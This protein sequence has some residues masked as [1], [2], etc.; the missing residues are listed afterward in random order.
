[1]PQLLSGRLPNVKIG[2]PSYS[3]D[4]ATLSVVGI[5]SLDKIS[6]GG[7]IGADG[8]YLVSTGIGLTWKTLSNEDLSVVR[9]SYDFAATAGQTTFNLEYKVGYADVFV[10][11]VLLASSE[12]TATDGSSIVLSEALFAGDTVQVV[13]YN[14][15][16][17][18]SSGGAISAG[19]TTGNY[20]QYLMSTGTGLEWEDFPTLRSENN[21]TATAGQTTFN[22]TY[23][24]GF[25]DV[26]VNGVRLTSVDYT[27]SNGTS[28]VL[29][30]ALFADDSVDILAYNTTSTG[31][32]GGGGGSE[33]DTLDS[34]TS[35]GSS[36]TNSITVGA[37][38][39]ASFIKDPNSNGLLRA[40]GT[41]DPSTYL[42]SES[43]TLET[44]LLRGAEAPVGIQVGVVTS[45]GGVYS[46]VI[47]R[48]SDNSTNTK[49]GLD[50]KSLKLYAGN[51]VSAKVTIN[52]A[53]G[54][55]T[56]LNVVGE[57]IFN[58]N[59]HVGVIT[60]T[61]PGTTIQFT[62]PVDFSREVSFGNIVDI[63]LGALTVGA[64][65]S[66][67]VVGS[68]TTQLI[69]HGDARVTGILTVG[70]SSITLNGSTDTITATTFDGNATSATTASSATTANS[71]AT[72]TSAGY[73]SS[74]VVGSSSVVG[75]NTSGSN[76]NSIEFHTDNGTNVDCR[77]RMTG[78]GHLIPSSNAD[79]DIGNAEYKVRHLF[80]S[81]NSLFT[82]SGKS[83][84]FSDGVL[85]WG[86]EPVIMQSQLKNIVAESTSFEDFKER[87]SNL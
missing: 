57:S 8:Q 49:I 62:D 26:Y 34:V 59:I 78:G 29:N 47:R 24:V 44:V 5:S 76:V 37:I 21:Y 52:G 63:P 55:N 87:I 11:G 74:I 7:S 6:V 30:E 58:S 20:G 17:V 36:T 38:T 81:D 65:N 23:N 40:D 68:A 43:D 18:V 56:T 72:A 13:A 14:P 86:D 1:M 12:Y 67:V 32:G 54:I 83:L 69:V 48:H 45:I 80:L 25:V 71:A 9:T 19:G 77:W 64:G 79:Y 16:A 53:V 70:T 27:A 41:E 28:I 35:R 3:E 84:S 10:N 66:S 60:G 4:L 82:A 61:N 33:T 2:I 50:A 15:F 51:G 42:T 31:G 73:A 22:V 75:F 39:A 46:D 85:K